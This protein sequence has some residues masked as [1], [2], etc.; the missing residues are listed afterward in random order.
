MMNVMIEKEKIK[1]YFDTFPRRSCRRQCLNDVKMRT[2]SSFNLK[3]NF[4]PIASDTL[5]NFA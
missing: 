4:W 2:F 3:K 1:L 5:A